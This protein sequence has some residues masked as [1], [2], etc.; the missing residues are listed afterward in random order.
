MIKNHYAPYEPHRG[1]KRVQYKYIHI[2]MDTIDRSHCWMNL[3][4]CVHVNMYPK[5]SGAGYRS[6]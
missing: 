5:L 2:Q 4:I 1:L 6:L 3:V